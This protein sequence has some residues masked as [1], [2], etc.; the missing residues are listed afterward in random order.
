VEIEDAATAPAGGVPGEA[1]PADGVPGAVPADG[2]PPT[3]DPRVDEALGRLSELAGLP[4]TEHPAV[5]G[6]I[7]QRLAEVLGDLGPA[8]PGR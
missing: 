5:F 6:H 4:V 3:G 2:V 1:V 7:H 8:T